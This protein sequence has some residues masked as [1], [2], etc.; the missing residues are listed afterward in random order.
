[1]SE[2]WVKKDVKKEKLKAQVDEVDGRKFD[3]GKRQ[4]SGRQGSPGMKQ[5]GRPC[6]ISLA[7]VKL[8]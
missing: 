1:M 8:I 7:Q 3:G 2:E 4:I 5:G 6:A